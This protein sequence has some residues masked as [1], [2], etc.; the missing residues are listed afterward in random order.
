MSH[1]GGQIAVECFE[2]CLAAP[3]RTRQQVLCGHDDAVEPVDCA[4]ATNAADNPDV[5][6]DH[7]GMNICDVVLDQ[8]ESVGHFRDRHSHPPKPY[9]RLIKAGLRHNCKSNVAWN[10]S[11]FGCGCG[12]ATPSSARNHAYAQRSL[13]RHPKYPGQRNCSRCPYDEQDNQRFELSG[14]MRRSRLFLECAA[15]D[16]IVVHF[17]PSFDTRRRETQR[18]SATGSRRHRA[19]PLATDRAGTCPPKASSF[20]PQPIRFSHEFPLRAIGG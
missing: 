14:L 1:S 15:R 3:S 13:A 4:A 16:L 2:R 5:V 10:S 6:A 8:P 19:N 9:H 7:F 20:F 18:T 12:K 17:D 11:T